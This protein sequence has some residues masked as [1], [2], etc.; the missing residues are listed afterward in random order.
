[1]L[2]RL[3]AFALR[4]A[5]LRWVLATAVTMF[6]LVR[7]LPRLHRQTRAEMARAARRMKAP[8][9]KRPSE[10]D[11]RRMR[12]AHHRR[13]QR[14][15]ARWVREQRSRLAQLHGQARVVYLEALRDLVA[16]GEEVSEA[17]R[18]MAHRVTAMPL[19]IIRGAAP[20][21]L[22]PITERVAA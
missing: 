6:A 8:T 16:T 4:F 15:R 18:A 19:H 5:V 17:R 12:L 14:G 11:L 1:M 20:A 22:Q 2:Q 3:H 7:A 10:T 9:P 13:L 21:P